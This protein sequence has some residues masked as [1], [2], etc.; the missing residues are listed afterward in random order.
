M[1]E[2]FHGKF[3]ALF[4]E[5][6]YSKE[7]GSKNIERLRNNVKLAEDLGAV[8]ETVYGDDVPYQV[9]E[10]SKVSGV[11]KIIIGRSER[12][13]N[14]FASKIGVVDR[15]IELAPDIDIYVIPDK[16]SR[17]YNQKRKYIKQIEL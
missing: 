6:T 13:R 7:L 8:I 16:E 14:I 1:A 2:A 3:I 5:T 9:A 12:R 10:F 15:L 11:S 17:L 4:V